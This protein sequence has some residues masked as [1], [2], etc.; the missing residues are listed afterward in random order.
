M[1]ISHYVSRPHCPS[2][3]AWRAPTGWRRDRPNCCRC[4]ISMSCS[5]CR[6]R[7]P[8]SRSTNKAAVYAILFHA[9]TEAL[10][11]VAGDP[12]YLGARPARSRCCTPGARRASSPHLHCI[13]PAAASRPTAPLGRLSARL[14]PAGA[15]VVAPL[16]RRVRAAAARR[17]RQRD[18][19]LLEPSRRWPT[20]RLRRHL[21]AVAA[22]DWVVFASRRSPAPSRCSA[23]RPLHPSRRHR[24]QPPGRDRR[25]PVSFTWKTIARKARSRR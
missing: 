14:L 12:R 4:R 6:R 24:Q 10:R 25:R 8:I 15:P 17:L 20:R 11:D 3:R 9:A 2:A 1:G 13:V 21:D 5:P 18:L 23:I 16:P 22:I 19:R 7:S